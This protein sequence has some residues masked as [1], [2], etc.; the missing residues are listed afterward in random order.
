MKTMRRAAVLATLA[1]SGAAGAVAIEGELRNIGQV[2]SVLGGQDVRVLLAS[3]SQ[4]E[5]V[6]LSTLRGARFSLDIPSTFRLRTV[7]MNLCPGVTAQRAAHL[8]RRE[9]SGLSGRQE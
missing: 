7:P 2:H 3:L 5:L 6:G 1:V 4:G 8:H 9:S